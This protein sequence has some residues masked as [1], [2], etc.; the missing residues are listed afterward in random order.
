MYSFTVKYLLPISIYLFTIEIFICY[1]FILQII[2]TD[3]IV[4]DNEKSQYINIYICLPKQLYWQ[5]CCMF[6]KYI[7]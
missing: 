5:Y 4:L 6:K 2:C 7:G 3:T 1:I